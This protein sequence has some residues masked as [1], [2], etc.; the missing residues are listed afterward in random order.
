VQPGSDQDERDEVTESAVLV[1]GG[2]LVGLHAALDLADAGVASIVVEQ[3]SILGGKRAALLAGEG[4]VDPRLVAVA[5]TEAIEILTMAGLTRLDGEAGD[6]TAVISQR[7][8]YVNDDCTRC[9]HCVPVCP[10]AVPN[11]YNAGL[12][13]RKA[14]HSPL[15]ET[16]PNIYSIDIDTCLNLPPNYLPC[17]RCVEVCD[18][19]AIHFDMLVPEPLERPVAAVIL[20]TGYADNDDAERAVL[21]E[22]GYGVH[23]DILSSVE[24]QRLLENPGPSGGY[25]IKP[26]NEAYPDSVLLVLTQVTP[27]TAWVMGNQLRRLADQDIAELTVLILS[28]PE[29]SPELDALKEIA[30]SCQASLL[31]GTWIGVE[32]VEEQLQARYVELPAGRSHE[33]RV[34]LVALSSAVHADQST[35]TLAETFALARDEQGYLSASRPGIYVVGGAHGTVGIERGAE[36]A[37]QAVQDALQHLPV[38]EEEPE[39]AADWAELPPAVKQQYLEQMLHSLIK[40]GESG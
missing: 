24:L 36:Q 12:T 14:I 35:D 11:E 13:F 7:P 9:N 2:G 6:F 38:P 4:A 20:A 33:Q 8:R 31:W 26:S 23:P 34:D 17:Q 25:A 21:E 32:A 19:K 28:T 40:L 29:T 27:Y 39:A 16:I 1:V 22:F 37:Q 30:A 5:D 18:D 15:P 10:E 3:G